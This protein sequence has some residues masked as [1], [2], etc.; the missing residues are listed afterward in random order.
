MDSVKLYKILSDHLLWL[1]DD[2]GCRANLS[3]ADL[4][5]AN[6]RHANLSNADLRHADLDYS[7]W[8]L[9]CNSIGV[10]LCNKL[11]SQLLYHAFVNSEIK[12]NKKQL[13]F[14]KD[15]FHRYKE[16]KQLEV[17]NG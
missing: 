9:S 17:D 16:V 15:N 2:G 13:K 6:L 3:G 14:I 7:C 11:Q 10:K 5:D 12:P 1:N 8:P 4:R